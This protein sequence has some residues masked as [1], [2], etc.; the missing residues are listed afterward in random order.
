MAVRRKFSKTRH[1]FCIFFHRSSETHDCPLSPYL[2]Y[3]TTV[4]DLA[5]EAQKLCC[6]RGMIMRDVGQPNCSRDS[7]LPLNPLGCRGGRSIRARLI[8]FLYKKTFGSQDEASTIK[9]LCWT[10]VACGG[11]HDFRS[12][13]EEIVSEEMRCLQGHTSFG[14]LL[15]NRNTK[16]SKI[17]TTSNNRRASHM[18]TRKA[19]IRKNNVKTR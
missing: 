13:L 4:S 1:H 15:G 17:Y 18:E 9:P 7:Q 14:C 12:E 16:V 5:Q 3:S 8:L 19:K 10:I 6:G 2:A 11:L